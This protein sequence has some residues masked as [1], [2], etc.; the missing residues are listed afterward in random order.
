MWSTRTY[1]D[2]DYFKSVCVSIVNMINETVDR[3][4]LTDW[5]YSSTA[6]YRRFRNRSVVGGLFINLI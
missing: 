5:Y 4:P 3:V 6:A 2:Q 1:D